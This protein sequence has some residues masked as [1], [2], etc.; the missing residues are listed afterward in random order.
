MARWEAM[1]GSPVPA[2][3]WQTV[4]P[5]PLHSGPDVAA[6]CTQG[7]FIEKIAS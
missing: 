6:K 5:T 4:S 3:F 1:T 2:H 7:D